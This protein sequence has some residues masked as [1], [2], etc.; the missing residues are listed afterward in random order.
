MT[1]RMLRKT[2]Q[3]AGCTCDE[4]EDG[5]VAVGRVQGVMGGGGSMM[6]F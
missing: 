4:A 2:L 1:R 3:A 6:P 5:Q